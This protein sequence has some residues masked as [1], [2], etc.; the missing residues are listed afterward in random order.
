MFGRQHSH[1]QTP[2][3]GVHPSS[4]LQQTP[5]IALQGE[6]ALATGQRSIDSLLND[7]YI[8]ENWEQA[9]APASADKCRAVF[10]AKCD[11]LGP[12]DRLL[13]AGAGPALGEWNVTRALALHTSP[14]TYPYW[15]CIVDVPATASL[16]YKLVAVK[17]DGAVEWE[18]MQNRVLQ[19]SSRSVKAEV[20]WGVAGRPS[21]DSARLA[22]PEPAVAVA[23]PAAGPE[24][25]AEAAAP[26]EIPIAAAAIAAAAA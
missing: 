19:A 6:A 11:R 5:T 12:A 24:S 2:S 18:P 8:P 10:L 1:D 26:S 16:E 13:A 17:A 9:L 4:T 22:G 14:S 23:E 20:E 3:S 25:G 7:T 15:F 21:F